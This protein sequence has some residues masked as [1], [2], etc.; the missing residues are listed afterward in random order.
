MTNSERRH[1]DLLRRLNKVKETVRKKVA[2]LLR[3]SR[4]ALGRHGVENLTF[5]E[6][7]Q[8]LKDPPEWLILEQSRLVE[9][10]KNMKDQVNAR[11]LKEQNEQAL[12]AELF[13]QL[14]DSGSFS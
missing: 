3:V 4:T 12:A 2:K 9:Y 10:K 7:S 1:R 11:K 6:A 5:E 13:R 8:L 14:K